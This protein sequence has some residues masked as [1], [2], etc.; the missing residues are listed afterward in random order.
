[1][2]SILSNDYPDYGLGPNLRENLPFLFIWGTADLTATPFV[3]GKSKK[4]INRYQDVALEGRGHWIMVEAK[5]EITQIVANWLESLT[6]C[7]PNVV[8]GERLSG[9][10]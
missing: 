7:Q 9:K 10:L 2:C 6:S 8:P 4:F 1:M 5:D 3:I